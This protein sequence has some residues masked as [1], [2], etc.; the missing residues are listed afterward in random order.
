MAFYFSHVPFDDDFFRH[1]STRSLSR[2][3]SVLSYPQSS[4]WKETGCL[5]QQEAASTTIYFHFP[6]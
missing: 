5:R 1:S 4:S 6:E 3:E 2:Q